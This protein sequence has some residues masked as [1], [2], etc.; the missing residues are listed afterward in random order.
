MVASDVDV[1]VDRGNYNNEMEKN[2][3]KMEEKSSRKCVSTTVGSMQSRETI[4][5]R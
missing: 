3:I 4:S 2:R 5:G 1:D